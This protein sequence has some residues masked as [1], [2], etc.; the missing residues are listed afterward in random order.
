MATNENAIER[1]QKDAI[2]Y[3]DRVFKRYLETGDSSQLCS[4]MNQC[5]LNDQ[6]YLYWI[7]RRRA[8][9][10]MMNSEKMP[11]SE[12]NAIEE[13]RKTMLQMVKELINKT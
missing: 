2:A 7:Q 12:Y 11:E 8:I 13:R 1:S 3:W 6:A 4:A 9:D 10:I 5:N